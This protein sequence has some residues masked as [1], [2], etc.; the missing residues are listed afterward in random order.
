MRLP[1]TPELVARLRRERW[2]PPLLGALGGIHGV[3]LVG[4]AVRDL[5]LDR[6]PLDLDLVVEGD[7]PAVAE[8]LA[9]RLEGRRIVH[10]RFGTATVRSDALTFDMVTARAERYPEPGALPEVRAGTLEEDL[11]RRD[12]TVN[13]I[14]MSLDEATL[15][16]LRRVSHALEDLADGLVRVLHPASFRDDPTRLLR[17]VRYARRLDF[18]LEADT[19][20]LAREAIAAGA[21]D[22]VSG[23]RIRDE[24]LDLLREPSVVRGLEGL[25]DLALDRA[26][27]VRADPDLTARALA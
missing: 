9:R 24:L 20:A 11:A 4:G 19:E 22:T 18:A 13:A 1:D 14:A 17:A 21:M 3:H 16:E 12:F 5:L 2:A 26:L 7:A 6:S 27:G 15:G 10:A 23:A 25:A 8:E